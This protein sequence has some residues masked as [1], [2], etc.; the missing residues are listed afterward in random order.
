MSARLPG[1]E[2]DR[3]TSQEDTIQRDYL[4][5]LRQILETRFSESELRTL[6]FDLGISYEDL[7]GSEKASQAREL[8]SYLERHRR[9]SEL[10]GIGKRLRSD[11][12]WDE[13]LPLARDIPLA[14]PN[15][16][17]ERPY[18]ILVVEDDEGWRNDLYEILSAAGYE[19]DVV[20][21]AQQAKDR[22]RKANYHLATI[23]MNL[24]E[25]QE[26]RE[27]RQLLYYIQNNHLTLKCIVVSGSDLGNREVRDLF[28]KYG[29]TDYM[30]KGNDFDPV[31]FVSMVKRILL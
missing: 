14:S 7:P 8:V 23:D 10:V 17:V 31:D 13:T 4:I 9:I 12:S 18:R 22:F 25:E 29:V 21:N 6:C 28:K 5:K 2:S 19:V 15:I 11:I 24:S 20:G 3:V 16:L 1:N 27:G 26:A 30:G